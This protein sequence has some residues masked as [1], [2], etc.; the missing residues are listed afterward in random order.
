MRAGMNDD[1]WG[2]QLKKK[3]SVYSRATLNGPTVYN[4]GH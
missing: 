3:S 1:D 2:V 4:R